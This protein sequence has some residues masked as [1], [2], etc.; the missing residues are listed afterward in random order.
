MKTKKYLFAFEQIVLL[1]IVN[2]LLFASKGYAK[3]SHWN[4]SFVL[5][6]LLLNLSVFGLIAYSFLSKTLLRGQ[7]T[8]VTELSVFI[9]LLFVSLLCLHNLLQKE[10]STLIYSAL[11]LF[12]LSIS[13]V[14]LLSAYRIQRNN[15]KLVS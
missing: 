13:F 4:V 6:I 12:S 9:Y 5:P 10:G 3:P 11:G 7:Q 1:A 14:F 15:Q 8:L 2:Y